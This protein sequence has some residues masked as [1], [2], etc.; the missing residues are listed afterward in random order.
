MSSRVC[1]TEPH[2]LGLH[3]Q[4]RGLTPNDAPHTIARLGR[5]SRLHG[6]C[7]ASVQLIRLFSFGPTSLILRLG[8]RALSP[9]TPTYLTEQAQKNRLMARSLVNRLLSARRVNGSSSIGHPH[10]PSYPFRSPDVAR[11]I[12]DLPAPALCEDARLSK[13]YVQP[14]TLTAAP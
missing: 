4:T 8:V 14:F 1:R 5:G 13:G 10:T 7:S 6:T 12:T 2:H 3:E 9:V 11:Q